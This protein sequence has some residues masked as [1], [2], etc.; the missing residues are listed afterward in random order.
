M[1]FKLAE[2]RKR[3]GLSQNGLAKSINMTLQNVQHL[4]RR[5]KAVP[6]ETLNKLCK[7]LECV[8]ADLF[9]YVPDDETAA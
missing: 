4:E 1:I 9:E 2:V 5:A 6:F 3:K 7:S 8:P